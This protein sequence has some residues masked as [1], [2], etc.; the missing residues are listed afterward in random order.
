V[1]ISRMRSMVL[2]QK[3]WTWILMNNE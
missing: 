3:G 1:L 2:N